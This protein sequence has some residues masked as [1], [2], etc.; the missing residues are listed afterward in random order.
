MYEEARSSW[1]E[2]AKRKT[3]LQW[4]GLKAYHAHQR[5]SI[6]RY[7]P[8]LYFYLTSNEGASQD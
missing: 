2:E 8:R 1:V 5:Q 6:E 7:G 4:G 3:G